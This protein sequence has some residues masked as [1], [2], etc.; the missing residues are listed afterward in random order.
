[1]VYPRLSRIKPVK[2]G[3]VLA[4]TRELAIVHAREG[5][6]INALCPYVNVPHP[7]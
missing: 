4:M 6:R 7:C 5:I 3:G 2:Q 1:L